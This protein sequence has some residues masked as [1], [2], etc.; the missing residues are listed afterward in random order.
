MASAIL[1]QRLLAQIVTTW[2]Y[3]ASERSVLGT[4]NTPYLY[5]KHCDHRKVN[6]LPYN[7]AVLCPMSSTFVASADILLDR[8]SYTISEYVAILPVNCSAEHFANIPAERLN[9]LEVLRSSGLHHWA[10]VANVV[11]HDTMCG[12]PACPR[13]SEHTVHL[14]ALSIT[15]QHRP[16]GL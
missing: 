8:T 10:T 12:M 14:R 13:W 11:M 2:L 16:H 6:Q 15:T 1:S 5:V 9:A 3:A 7:L 4:G